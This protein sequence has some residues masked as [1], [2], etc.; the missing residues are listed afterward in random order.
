MSTADESGPFL[1]EEQPGPSELESALLRETLKDALSN[2]GLILDEQTPLE[3]AVR[4]MRERRQGCVLVTHEGRL[5]GIF[6]E[7]DVLMK[8]VGTRIDLDRTPLRPYMTRDPVTLP[9]DASVAYALNKMLLEGFRHVP[10]LDDQGRPA[11]VVSMRDII[12]YLGG[13]FAKDVL[14]LPPDPTKSFRNREGA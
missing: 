5:S 11:G 12:E 13:F 9:A 3:E 6:T 4:Q 2:P 10:L 8:V 7:R 14:N 1:D